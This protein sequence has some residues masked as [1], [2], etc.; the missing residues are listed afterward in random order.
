MYA[1]IDDFSGAQY[2]EPQYLGDPRSGSF[3]MGDGVSVSQLMN[4]NVDLKA[5]QHVATGPA[6]MQSLGVLVVFIVAMTA[7]EFVV[8]KSGEGGGRVRIGIENALYI[9][10]MAAVT[11]YM[12]RTGVNAWKGAPA[13]LKQF[14]GAI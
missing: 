4:P 13:A 9:F 12:F 7:I 2:A 8:R 11:F 5:T 14:A 6:W 3:N 10:M 1:E